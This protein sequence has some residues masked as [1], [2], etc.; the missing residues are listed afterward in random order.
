MTESM[1]P[2][3][4]NFARGHFPLSPISSNPCSSRSGFCA[5][6]VSSRSSS[7]LTP[8]ALANHVCSVPNCTHALDAPNQGRLVSHWLD[9]GWHER[10]ELREFQAQFTRRKSSPTNLGCSR[11]L[12]DD[13]EPYWFRDQPRIGSTHSTSFGNASPASTSGDNRRRR[14]TWWGKKKSRMRMCRCG[15]EEL[16]ADDGNGVGA[17]G[18]EKYEVSSDIPNDERTNRGGSQSDQTAAGAGTLE[19]ELFLYTV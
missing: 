10:L 1:E 15:S 18:E 13:L 3:C 14:G 12:F 6:R 17:G 4:A 11:S 9:I 2:A 16:N 5:T 19:S 8:P 7:P